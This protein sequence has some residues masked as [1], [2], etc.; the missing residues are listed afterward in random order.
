M[1]TTYYGIWCFANWNDFNLAIGYTPIIR[2]YIARFHWIY[3][4]LLCRF[5]TLL[6][7][8]MALR[9]VFSWNGQFPAQLFHSVLPMLNS[10]DCQ[11]TKFSKLSIIFLAKWGKNMYWAHFFRNWNQVT[12]IFFQIKNMVWNYH[13]IQP[14]LFKASN[15]DY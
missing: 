7:T 13:K 6:C 5:C 14:V 1:A 11:K 9:M 10:R 3:S 12:T 15:S 2:I 4:A 8:C